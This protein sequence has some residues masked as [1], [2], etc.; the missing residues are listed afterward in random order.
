MTDPFDALRAPVE[1]LDPDPS[2]ADTLRARLQRALLDPRGEPTMTTPSVRRSGTAESAAP[3]GEPQGHLGYAALWVPDVDRAAA[4]FAAV[5]GW[6]YSAGGPEHRMVD[7]ASPH[8]GIVAL[9]ALP[10]GAWDAWPR[11]S[12]LFISHAV[13]DVDAAA[14]RVRAAGGQAGTPTDE[15]YG[16]MA[17]CVD[18]QGIPFSVHQDSG[19]GASAGA[20]SEA[21]VSAGPARLVYL[22]FEVADS[23]RARA[24]FGTVFGWGFSPGH[25]ADG[26]QVEGMTPMSGMQ[27]GHDQTAIVPMYAVEDVRATVSRVRQAGGSATDPERQPYGVT[28]SCADDQ[29]TRFYLGELG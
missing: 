3:A 4:F 13:A 2:F 23:A 16:R 18:D 27:G 5:L 20:G 19:A 7:G 6:S 26:W 28:S 1:P 12:T 9:S 14:Q 24:F 25:V 15:P 11:H 22:T 10:S 17:D 21:E 8:H 29:G